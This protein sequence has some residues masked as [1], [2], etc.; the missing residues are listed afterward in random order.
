MILNYKNLLPKVMQD[1]RWGQF[2]EAYQSLTD[3]LKEE[4]IYPILDQYDIEKMS[5]TEMQYI[6]DMFGFPL[7]VYTGYS[8]TED[9]LKKELLTIVKRILTKTTRKSYKY[10]FYI[11]NLLGDVYPLILTDSTALIVYDTWWRDNENPGTTNI[12]DAADDN[13]LYYLMYVTDT[14]FNKLD[15]SL[16]TDM[17]TIVYDS[18]QYSGFDTDGTLD[19]SDVAGGVTLNPTTFLDD[20]LREII[21][22]Y[23]FMFAE[24][25]TE[26]LSEYTLK[27]FHNDINFIK[28]KTEEIIFEPCLVIN[29]YDDF[30]VRETNYTNY[31]YVNIAKQT[32]I[33]KSD[34]TLSTISKIRFGTGGHITVNNSITD[35]QNYSFQLTSSQFE[36]ISG[37]TYRKILYQRCTMSN[38]SEIAIWNSSNICILYSKFPMIYFQEKKYHNIK[39]EFVID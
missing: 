34:A 35:V 20:V 21:V 13:I 29:A 24:S 39:L 19:M 2:A 25:A 38:F 3:T 1:T 12:L 7:S 23:K 30:T 36:I 8:S 10:T 22:S 6:A 33:C 9:Y 5:T 27:A 18:D 32:S 31:L 4:K 14:N 11:F 37:T 16:T 26:F 15:N 28:K 17:S